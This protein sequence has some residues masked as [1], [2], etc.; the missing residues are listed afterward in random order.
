MQE[1]VFPKM[2]VQI[3]L[4]SDNHFGHHNIYTF[5]YT[6]AYGVERRVRERFRDAVEG[7]A[8]MIQRWCELVRP[9]DHIWHLGDVCMERSANAKTWFVNKMRS[10]PGHKRLILGNH[11]H[12][13]MDVY[14]DAGFQ[15]I[16]ASNVIDG[17]LLTHYPVHPGSIGRAIGNC[18]GHTHQHPDEGPRYLNISVERTQY[19]PIPIETAK[20][21]LQAK[22]VAA[23]QSTESMLDVSGTVMD[24]P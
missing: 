13:A 18:H 17:L 11:D 24:G 21:L 7:D 1:K 4:T 6:D 22:I 9:E 12:L 14:R 2:S 3:W 8:Y 10:L 23:G 19:E 16:R 20:A 15:K 5:V